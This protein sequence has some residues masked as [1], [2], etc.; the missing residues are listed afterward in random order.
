VVLD[1]DGI[2]PNHHVGQAGC[3]HPVYPCAEVDEFADPATLALYGRTL[4]SV[5]DK[6]AEKVYAIDKGFHFLCVWQCFFRA[7]TALRLGRAK[8][9]WQVY[10]P[11]LLRVYSKS[12]GLMS[13]DASVVVG[14]TA[15]EA[16]LRHVPSLTLDDVG[17]KMPVFESWHG[18]SGTASPN[19][20]TKERSIP[21]IEA[22]ADYLTMMTE[23]LLQSHGGVIRVF[24]AWP[25]TREAR[26]AGL[27]AEGDVRVS[28]KISGGKVRFV[29]LRGGPN[30]GV[31]GS[32]TVRI[33]SPWTGK[34]EAYRLAPGGAITLTS[35][36][37]V[38]AAPVLK[39]GRIEGA[40]P[41]RLHQDRWASLWLG[42]PRVMNG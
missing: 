42:R 8:E 19:P 29:T 24:P 18:H 33:K 36:G 4:D 15:S 27:V 10:L 14:S 34:I 1:G 32:G 6:T 13:H 37:A 21:L 28:A 22:N 39:P 30:V 12:N 40:R 2:T 31:T 17:E 11:M 25:K 35:R 26:F 20:R 38:K 3:L 9:F 5:V 41:R 23:T 16:N 7:M